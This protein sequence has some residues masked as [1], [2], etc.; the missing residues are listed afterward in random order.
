VYIA[1]GSDN[2]THLLQTNEWATMINFCGIS[3]FCE[4]IFTLPLV[5]K[6]PISAL[7][8]GISSQLV[9]AYLAVAKNLK[10]TLDF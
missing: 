10:K 9:P 5:L 3:A 1:A 2:S 4:K 6:S 7:L 8:S